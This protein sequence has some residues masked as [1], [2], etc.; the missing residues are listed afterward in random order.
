MMTTVPDIF[1]RVPNHG[2]LTEL[3]SWMRYSFESVRKIRLFRATAGVAMHISSR[4]FLPSNSYFGPALITKVSPSSLKQKILPSHAQ[5]EA[6][7]A[8][9]LGS[10]RSLV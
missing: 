7:K 2:P 1:F 3:V 10:I 6:V 5:G 8:F 9:S 4:L